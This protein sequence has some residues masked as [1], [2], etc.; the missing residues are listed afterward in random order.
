MSSSSYSVMSR[1]ALDLKVR[2]MT[3]LS[4]PIIEIY[5][6]DTSRSVHGTYVRSFST[7]DKIEGEVRITAKND[8]RFDE[9]NITF[10]GVA[11]TFVDNMSPITTGATRVEKYRRFLFLRQPIDYSTQVPQPRIIAAGATVT[12]PFM[13]VVPQKLPLS[14][15]THKVANDHVKLAHLQVPPSLGDPETSGFGGRLLDDSAPDM[16]R[17]QYVLR[18]RLSRN[19]DSD[20]SENM[21]AQKSKK[22]RIKPAVDEAPP[23][24]A[25]NDPDYILRCEKGLRKFSKGRL[26]RL[27]IE[28]EQPQS[29]RLP[30]SPIED[31]GRPVTTKARAILR[32]D[33]A[34]PN[35]QPPRLGSL[36]A[37][38]RAHTFFAA[39]P[40]NDFSSKSIMPYDMS[41]GHFDRGFNIFNHCMGGAQWERHDP[42]P[43]DCSRS[44]SHDSTNT[45]RTSSGSIPV[46]AP[47]SEK[48]PKP[49]CPFYTAVFLIPLT[50]PTSR[51]FPPTFHSCLISRIYT[52]SLDLTLHGV[53]M[54]NPKLHLRLPVQV[55]DEGSKDTIEERRRSEVEEQE[56]WEG[57]F[58]AADEYFAPRRIGQPETELPE[59]R[60]DGLPGYDADIGVRGGGGAARGLVRAVG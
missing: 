17:I 30:A 35:E 36:S 8:T 25:D 58:A 60:R 48:P 57:A 18:V 28:A 9:I 41:Q 26:G 32:F 22:V 43:S 13:F 33:P 51:S 5:L 6:K 47:S 49:G 24:D 23:V 59:Q 7:L 20:G 38:L 52:L 4:K 45:R 31:A 42:S 29:F 14:S 19:R 44:G 37:L 40:R 16:A 21:L 10:E 15:C 12:I 39:T 55:S 56:R 11:F 46:P 50:L 3:L 2:N 1:E 34:S 54:M 27:I 53:S